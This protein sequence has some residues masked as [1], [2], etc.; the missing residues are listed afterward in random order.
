MGGWFFLVGKLAFPGKEAESSF[1][2]TPTALTAATS[3]CAQEISQTRV[4]VSK[5]FIVAGEVGDRQLHLVADRSILFI[6]TGER[7]P[8]EHLEN[9]EC[10]A[11]QKLWRD[12]AGRPWQK[13]CCWSAKKA[14]ID[15]QT[16]LCRC[17]QLQLLYADVPG[18][19]LPM[20]SL[21]LIETSNKI[22]SP[23]RLTADRALF[24]IAGR[25]SVEQE[26]LDIAT[27]GEDG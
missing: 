20:P 24:N 13:I 25:Y 12:E 10:F 22:Y 23:L 27:S 11:Q 19:R 6:P 15:Y 7:S 26:G 3:G 8:R 9:V 2:V 5:E 14:Q 1:L 16:M 18:H 4:G 17:S 21:Q